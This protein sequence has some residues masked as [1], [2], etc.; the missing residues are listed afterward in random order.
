MALP[1]IIQQINSKL[2]LTG[3]NMSGN[4]VFNTGVLSQTASANEIILFASADKTTPSSKSCLAMRNE[5]HT[6]EPGSFY[7]RSCHDTN[8]SVMK[9][10]PDGT[11]TWR[12]NNVITSAGGTINGSL[13]VN[14]TIVSVNGNIEAPNGNI[15]G[16]RFTADNHTNDNIDFMFRHITSGGMYLPGTHARN[17]EWYAITS[18]KGS[19]YG[20]AN[21]YRIWADGLIEQWGYVGGL[22]NGNVWITFPVAFTSTDYCL[23]TF[24]R[25]RS[26]GSDFSI[27]SDTYYTTGI[28]VSWDGHPNDPAYINWYAVGY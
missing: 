9:I 21:N 4:I 28:T 10:M 17:D 6:L 7:I 24:A 5:N 2:P 15:R 19:Y 8:S 13:S 12:G 20:G 14:G 22:S 18:L 3:G 1:N 16:A 27:G 26:A 23:L 25:G 11:F